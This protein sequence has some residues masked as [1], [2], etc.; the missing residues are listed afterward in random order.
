MKKYIT[1]F[2][3]LRQIP[4]SQ[5]RHYY[6]DRDLIASIKNFTHENEPMIGR[7]VI[8]ASGII[9]APFWE[10]SND[11]D[12]EGRAFQKYIQNNPGFEMMIREKV[13][14]K[15]LDA[16]KLLPKN[17]QIVLKAGLRPLIVQKML[18]EE[19]VETEKSTHPDWD[20][21]TLYRHCLTYVT[22]PDKYISPHATGGAVDILTID[23]KSGE[24]IDMGSPINAVGDASW[25]D[26][27]NDFTQVQKHN[28]NTLISTMIKV[29][30]ANLAS[31]W[32]HFSYGDPRWAIFYD[33]NQARYP[34]FEI[35]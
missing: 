26:F 9:V 18:F 10:D 33:K 17:W 22:D 20:H 1:T 16:Q 30:F 4:I 34:H 27:G 29:G 32:W 21:D 14:K 15:L 24:I 35:K 6:L 31:E 28:R 19:V 5:R 25:C 23:K 3:Q 11:L 7:K 12:E 2:A 13:L 8:E